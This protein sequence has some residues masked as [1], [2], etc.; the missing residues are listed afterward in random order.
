MDTLVSN[1]TELQTTN[2]WPVINSIKPVIDKIQELYNKYIVNNKSI[3]SSEYSVLFVNAFSLKKY[4]EEEV[5][6]DITKI[7]DSINTKISELIN[8][9]IIKADT[10]KDTI[11]KNLIEDIKRIHQEHAKAGTGANNNIIEFKKV[12]ELATKSLELNEKG[13]H[14]L[15]SYL[16]NIE[17][18]NKREEIRNSYQAIQGEIVTNKDNL[19]DSILK[20]NESITK[21][22]NDNKEK[23]KV[24]KEKV[25]KEKRKRE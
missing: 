10:E 17:D 13:L 5:N 24:E 3:T 25:E 2:I 7:K 4:L 21:T 1:I 15:L 18:A 20:A 22:I 8:T 11:K 19:T 12:T 9:V 6:K 16:L 14:T 23:E